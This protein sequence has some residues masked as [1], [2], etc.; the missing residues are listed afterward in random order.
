MLKKNTDSPIYKELITINGEHISEQQ[1]ES[2]IL[3]LY[4]NQ[5]FKT[6]GYEISYSDG[7]SSITIYSLLKCPK[8]V[9]NFFNNIDP[10]RLRFMI[11]GASPACTGI[12]TWPN[13][14]KEVVDKSTFLMD[15]EN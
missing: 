14:F 15:K 13:G 4:K 11:L 9:I 3:S 8:K 10:V 7:E 12:Y 1:V 2:Y 5:G 6:L